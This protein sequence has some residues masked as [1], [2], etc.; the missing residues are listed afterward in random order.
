MTAELLDLSRLPAFS[1]TTV[2]YSAEVAA[3]K[4][5]IVARFRA[6][7]VPYDV[8][9]LETDPAM[10]LAEEFAYR[11]TLDLQGLNDAGR[12]LMLATSYGAALDHIAAT[13]YA[14]VIVNGAPIARLALVDAPRPY[15]TNPEDWETDDRF[16]LRI[17]LAGQARTSGTLPGYELAALTAAPYLTDA[18][19][20]NYSSGLIEQGEILV[21]VL[22][23]DPDPDPQ[24]AIPA[25]EEPA[26]YVLAANALLNP[27]TK[28]GSDVI[29]VRRARR[30]TV[31]RGYTLGVRTGPDPAL[32][33]AQARVRYSAWIAA[34]RKIG[35]A[36]A[37]SG[38]NAQ[39][40]VSGVRYVH[41]KPGSGDD[42]DPGLD[43][44]VE[45][46]SLDLTTE[47]A[48]G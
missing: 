28:L 7:G 31:A 32:V 37:A 30:V 20:L 25:Q 24:T 10:V 14:D 12:R 8:E 38:E 15:S 42:V 21:V 29:T 34:G 5:A 2:D 33:L 23:R 16:R 22:G 19:A 4:A 36:L 35:N 48:G 9:T 11:K 40:Y 44:V 26:Q 17:G 3:L 47:V 45:V 6:N 39:L 13:Y 41:A 18:V 27:Q 46:S 1:L 43:G